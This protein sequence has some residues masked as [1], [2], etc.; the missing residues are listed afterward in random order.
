MPAMSS[1]ARRHRL[2]GSVF[3]VA[4]AALGTGCAATSPGAGPGAETLLMHPVPDDQFTQPDGTILP[5]RVWLPP[6]GVAPRAVVLA[7]HGFNDSR[8]A[9][10]LPAPV[11]AAAGIAMFAPDLRG[12]GDTAARATWPGVDTLVDDADAMARALRQRYPGVPLYVMGES[13]G[14]AIAMDLAARP[15][16]PPVDGYVLL[17]PAVWGRSEQGVVLSSTLWLADGV[18]PGYRITA[19]DVPVHVTA[20]DNRDALIA[21]VRD[22]LTIHGTRVAAL[23]G[24]VDLMDSA[25]AAAPAVHG[26]VLV[27]YGA[28]DMLVPEAAMGVAWAKLPPNV[29]RA[30]YPNGYHLLLRDKGRQAVI[31][32]VIA[33]MNAPSAMLPSGA[34]IAASA[35]ASIHHPGGGLAF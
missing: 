6:G 23:S 17:A 11:F 8:D 20:S 32:D 10:A 14:G 30:V 4:F 1:T 19:S 2:L 12:F 25:Q 29:R 27:A 5:A 18:L 34:D 26:R 35:W 33:W 7:L 13:M 15:D 16:G 22:P 21:L 28:R 24:L 3:L 9:W 31:G